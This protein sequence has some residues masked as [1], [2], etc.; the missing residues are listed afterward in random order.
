MLSTWFLQLDF[1]SK[2]KVGCS[3]LFIMSYLSHLGY[4]GLRRLL[5]IVSSIML[6][7]GLRVVDKLMDRDTTS[8][9][10]GGDTSLPGSGVGSG[11]MV[12]VGSGA[13]VGGQMS[14]CDHCLV[15]VESQDESPV[16]SES[17][18]VAP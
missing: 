15:V 2:F 14:G 11:A 17:S 1:M 5:D 9:P 3:V 18:L 12:G 8:A 10:R 13:M 4:Y 7:V 6:K 16:S